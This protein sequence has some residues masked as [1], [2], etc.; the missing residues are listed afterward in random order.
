MILKKL[1]VFLLLNLILSINAI[2][3]DPEDKSVEIDSQPESLSILQKSITSSIKKY[4]KNSK[5]NSISRCP[6]N[7]SCSTLFSKTL[8][9]KGIIFALIVFIDRNHYRE[10]PYSYRYYPAKITRFPY[11]YKLLDQIEEL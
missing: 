2:E 11:G 7:T 1:I 9:S 5:D 3:W 4:R 10:H 8:K 6:F